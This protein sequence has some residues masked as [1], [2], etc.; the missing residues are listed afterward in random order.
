MSTAA[1]QIEKVARWQDV[2][3]EARNG[4]EVTDGRA[5]LYAGTL[6][7]RQEDGA[8]VLAL[9]RPPRAPKRS[10]DP[11]GRPPEP[12]ATAK[13]AVA[14]GSPARDGRRVAL[15]SGARVAFA[16]V[17]EASAFVGHLAPA[18]AAAAAHGAAFPDLG[19]PAV[20]R[21]VA[22]LLLDPDFGRFVG[23]VGTFCDALRAAVP[24]PAPA[25]TSPSP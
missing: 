21:Y 20:Q 13:V 9:V 1:E 23:D 2:A 3:L 12:D 17:A 14:C 25:A 22:G 15:A 5:R 10:A 7:L 8:F 19:R 11:G 4:V 6:Q 16:T 24:A 18:T